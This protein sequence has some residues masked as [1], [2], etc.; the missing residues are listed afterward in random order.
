[1]RT[2]HIGG[3]LRPTDPLKITSDRSSG[4][5]TP[6]DNRG[7]ERPSPRCVAGALG[8]VDGA[9]R[10]LGTRPPTVIALASTAGII[11]RRSG[12]GVRRGVCR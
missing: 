1:M 7:A 9:E 6:R 5:S 3:R 4:P 11:S 8:Q 2:R 10:P 12:A